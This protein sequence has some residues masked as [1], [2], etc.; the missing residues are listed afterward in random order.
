MCCFRPPCVLIG[1]FFR[2]VFCFLCVRVAAWGV[3]W[4]TLRLGWPS[5]TCPGEEHLVLMR[6][7][8]RQSALKGCAYWPSRRRHRGRLS[9]LHPCR[10]PGSQR[11]QLGG[12]CDAP[13][14]QLGWRGNRRAQAQA[15]Q[16]LWPSTL[17]SWRHRGP[18]AGHGSAL[19]ALEKSDVKGCHRR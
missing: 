2:E 9:W 15:R 3:C 16:V 17:D 12:F 11:L 6:Q 14:A 19:C 8:H 5:P 7:G 1:L 18:P 13:R 4:R 10:L